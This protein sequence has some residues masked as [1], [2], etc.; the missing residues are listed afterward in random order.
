MPTARNAKGIDIV[1]YKGENFTGIQ[2]KALS[3]KNPVPMG[4]AINPKGDFWIIVVLEEPITTYI[5]DTKTF[6]FL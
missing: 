1:A 6:R 4:S 5:L 3:K 2:V